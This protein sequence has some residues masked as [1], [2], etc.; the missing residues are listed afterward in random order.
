MLL[1]T[2][3]RLSSWSLFSWKLVLWSAVELCR[4]GGLRFVLAP[5]PARFLRIWGPE[6]G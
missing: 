1:G 4:R 3:P 6:I 5:K 2:R